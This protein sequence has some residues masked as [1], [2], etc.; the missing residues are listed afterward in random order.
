MRKLNK[1]LICLT[2]I[3]CMLISNFGYAYAQNDS[4]STWQSCTIYEGDNLNDQSY[5]TNASTI[6][7]YL[8]YTEEGQIMRVQALN[9]QTVLV[10]YYTDDYQLINNKIIDSN[11][12]PVFGGFYET[13]EYYFIVSGQNNLSEDDSLEVYRISKFDKDWNFVASTGLSDCNTTIPF[14]SGTVRMDNYGDYLLIRTSHQMYTHTDGL[15]HQ[16]NVTIQVRISDMTI[17]D[18]YTD[19]MNTAYGYVSHSFNQFIKIDEE[20]HIIAVDHGDAYPRSIVLIEYPTDVSTGSFSSRNCSVTNVFSFA[21][22]TGLNA[23]RAS[24]GGFELAEN[25]YLIAGNSI[26]Q[27]SNYASRS[28][29]NIYVWVV[30]QDTKEITTKQITNYQEGDGTTSTPHLVKVNDNQFILLWTEDEIIYYVQL[31][32]N[33]NMVSDIYEL[34]GDLSDCVPITLNNNLVWYTWDDGNITFYEINLSDL[35]QTTIKQITNGHEY[36]LTGVVDADAGV[37]E[38]ECIHCGLK[39][40]LGYYQTMSV[41]WN[42]TGDGSYHGSVIDDLDVGESS[43]YYIT[44]TFSASTCSDEFEVLIED[45]TVLSW[46]KT[47]NRLGFLTGLKAGT[48]EIV[49][50]SKLNPSLSRSYNFTVH[51]PL[52]ISSFTADK[53]E[54]IVALSV[55]ASGG[56]GSLTYSFYQ[57]DDDGNKSIIY[58][59][60]NSYCNWIPKVAGKNTLYVDVTDGITTITKSVDYIVDEDDIQI[61][62]GDLNY[63]N[64]V[65]YNDAV[66]ILQVDSNSIALT[67]A[68]KSIAD[69][70]GDN[71]IDYN[72]AV[73]ILRKDAGL[74]SDF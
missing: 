74:I 4:E 6:K 34:S 43:Y 44:A 69:V 35:N 57:I 18:S 2:S 72:D 66:I 36:E 48:T 9:N 47:S 20:G 58:Q 56:E 71:T 61:L 26:I 1:G 23:T 50:R 65:D 53:D 49:I 27:D 33:G 45:P 46:T 31:D 16:A 32:G 10:E 24:V 68:Q 22:T 41:Y 55:N 28:T 70:N 25:N 30:D 19:V 29:R 7:S 39:R 40:Y 60:E 42:D 59:G 13:D 17:T 67:E 12:L 54:N 64:K 8:S 52:E 38:T 3:L 62:L 14:R 73:L 21:G 15:R 37:A 51:G 63:D 11:L 5:S